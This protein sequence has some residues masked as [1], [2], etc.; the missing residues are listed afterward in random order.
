[1]HFFK[2]N[3]IFALSFTNQSM[4]LM[5]I[6]SLS[7]LFLLCSAWTTPKHKSTIYLYIERYA[8]RAINTMHDSG[9]PA[10]I[11][12]AMAIEESAAGTSEVAREANNH[13]G[14]KGGAAWKQGLYKTKGGSS[15][16][17][18]AT[19]QESYEDFALLLK[20]NYQSLFKYSKT[21]YKNWAYALEKTNYCNAKGYAKRLLYIIDNH[22]LYNFDNCIL[23]FK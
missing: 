19:V 3:S 4:N 14:M 1:M 23:E 20:N 11:I 22:L 6:L 16:R 15:F 7:I 8:L 10:S 17:K 13:F 21:D 2:K 5:R 9:I 12:M 18:Y